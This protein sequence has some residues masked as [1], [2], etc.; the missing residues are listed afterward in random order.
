MIQSPTCCETEQQLC[1]AAFS[2][3]QQTEHGGDYGEAEGYG[4]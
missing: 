1:A 2:I 4:E 3:G